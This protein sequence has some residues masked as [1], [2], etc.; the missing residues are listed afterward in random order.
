MADGSRFFV[1]VSTLSAGQRAHRPRGPAKITVSVP[2]PPP[3]ARSIWLQR[4]LDP[5]RRPLRRAR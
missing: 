4:Q 5:S 3:N 2:L 1:G